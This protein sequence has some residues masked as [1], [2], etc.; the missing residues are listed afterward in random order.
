MKRVAPIGATLAAMAIAAGFGAIAAAT[1]WLGPDCRS[2]RRSIL[3][4]NAALT[5][6]CLPRSFRG[7]ATSS[8][9]V[10]RRN[11]TALH[12]LDEHLYLKPT[13]IGGQ[14]RDRWS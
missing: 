3:I 1:A 11:D 14:T 10:P 4:G 9:A 2:F 7:A 5:A 13:L 12:R 8:N 6:G